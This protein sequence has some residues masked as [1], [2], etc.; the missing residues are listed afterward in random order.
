VLLVS[1]RR[2]A[3]AIATRVIDLHPARE[4]PRSVAS[5]GLLATNLGDSRARDGG[6]V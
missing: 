2:S 4:S 1:H 3:R 5:D 6:R